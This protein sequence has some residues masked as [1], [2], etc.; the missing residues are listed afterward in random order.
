MLKKPEKETR[1]SPRGPFTQKQKTK[2]IL[3]KLEEL[4]G[5]G[6]LSEKEKKKLRKRRGGGRRITISI[7]KQK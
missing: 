2:S 7:K 4:G 1:F 3:G 6:P 5:E